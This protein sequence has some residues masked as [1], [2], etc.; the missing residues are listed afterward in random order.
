MPYNV[1]S[2][3]NTMNFLTSLLAFKGVQM[4]NYPKCNSISVMQLRQSLVFVLNFKNY[5]NHEISSNF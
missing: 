2:M 1:L 4:N 3:E 5:V